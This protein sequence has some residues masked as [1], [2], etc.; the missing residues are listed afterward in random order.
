MIDYLIRYNA[1][2]AVAVIVGLACA[3]ARNEL[4]RR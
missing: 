3:I 4:K 2:V 1:W